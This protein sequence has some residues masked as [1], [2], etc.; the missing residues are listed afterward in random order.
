MSLT[1]G[2]LLHA[3]SCRSE[4]HSFFHGPKL[5]PNPY[6]TLALTGSLALQGLAMVVPGLR[7]ILGLTP[8]SLVD[9]LV[10]G[11]TALTP[12]LVNEA[13]KG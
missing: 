1:I 7:A 6:F 9:A 8:I 10:I 13:A 3:I 4:K 5:P 2:Q 11:A 12:L